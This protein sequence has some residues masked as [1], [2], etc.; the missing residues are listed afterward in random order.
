MPSPYDTPPDG[1]FARLVEQLSQAAP[2]AVP[3]ATPRRTPRT[4]LPAAAQAAPDA[5]RPLR[6]TV[7]TVLFAL[8]AGVMLV[9]A[10]PALAPWGVIVFLA[11]VVAALVRLRRMPWRDIFKN[12]S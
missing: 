1:D 8:V 2:G 11:A 4:A 6:K 3:A 12:K 10:F 5:L 7:Q 9:S